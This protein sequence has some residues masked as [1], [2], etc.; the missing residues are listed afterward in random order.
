MGKHASKQKEMAER[1]S[2]PGYSRCE[3]YFSVLMEGYKKSRHAGCLG[4]ALLL[5]PHEGHGPRVP[6]SAAISAS[7]CARKADLGPTWSCFL[8]IWRWSLL[9]LSHL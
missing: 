8:L 7:T 6:A 9:K 5:S 4:G 1:F 2:V 3:Y